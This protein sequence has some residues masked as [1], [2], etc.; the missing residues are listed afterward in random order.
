MAKPPSH[1]A[2]IKCMAGR[3]GTA[4]SAATEDRKIDHEISG[5]MK[6]LDGNGAVIS[7]AFVSGDPS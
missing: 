1:A 2:P 6:E 4:F 5:S 3:S 7:R